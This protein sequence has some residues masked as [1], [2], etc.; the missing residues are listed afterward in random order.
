MHVIEREHILSTF[1]FL[2]KTRVEESESGK[3]NRH[4]SVLNCLDYFAWKQHIFD[5]ISIMKIFFRLISCLDMHFKT[6]AIV[7]TDL[8]YKIKK[9]NVNYKV[10][11]FQQEKKDMKTIIKFLC[12]LCLIIF[13]WGAPGNN[14]WKIWANIEYFTFSLG[15]GFGFI[16]RWN[17][18]W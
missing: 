12:I 9:K 15:F 13:A 17:Y 5:K 6:L 11:Y 3:N 10:S 8:V 1:F 14:R 18:R 7:L 2:T 4:L 16:Y